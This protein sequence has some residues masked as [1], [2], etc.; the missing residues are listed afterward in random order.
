MQ[1]VS[2][3]EKTRTDSTVLWWYYPWRGGAPPRIH[4]LAAAALSAMVAVDRWHQTHQV[5]AMPALQWNCLGQWLGI[6]VAT[7]S[8]AAAIKPETEPPV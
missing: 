8:V 2:E 1:I 4:G 5:A 3:S 7:L 6:A